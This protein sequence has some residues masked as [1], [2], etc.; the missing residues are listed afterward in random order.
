MNINRII[1]Q[2][3][4]DEE[5]NKDYYIDLISESKQEGKHFQTI[6]TLIIQGI[7]EP[8]DYDKITLANHFKN[9][10]KNIDYIKCHALLIMNPDIL[11]TH[12]KNGI[13]TIKTIKEHLLPL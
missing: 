2:A 11:E 10:L 1:E 4:H 9:E 7:T 3:I 5:I 8:Y 6:N 12:Y 13:L